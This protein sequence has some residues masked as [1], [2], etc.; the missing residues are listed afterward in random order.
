[1][2]EDY[3][4]K[5]TLLEGVPFEK[6]LSSL[7]FRKQKLHDLFRGSKLVVPKASYSTNPAYVETVPKNFNAIPGLPTRLPPPRNGNWPQD[8]PSYAKVVLAN[9]PTPSNA[10]LGSDGVSVGS[11]RVMN[12]AETAVAPPLPASPAADYRPADRNEIVARNR[13]GQRID[14]PYRDIDKAEVD[15]V[16]KL[17]L[18]NVHYL[19]NECPYGNKCPHRHNYQ[20]TEGEIAALRLVARLAPCTNGSGCEVPKCVYGHCCPAAPAK[21]KPTVK[22]IQTCT[23]GSACNFPP[24]LHDID[25][26][27]VKTLVIR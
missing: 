23:Y 14:P 10:T 27:M 11:R 21:T 26:N 15:R 25:R 9:S 7:P 16:K 24:E 8:S 6:E 2:A 4:T 12:W 3:S 1:M 17:K 5:V 18:C 13:A 20:P 19:L 22:G